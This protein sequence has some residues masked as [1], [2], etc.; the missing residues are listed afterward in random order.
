MS[1]TKAP[2]DMSIPEL[3]EWASSASEPD[4]ASALEAEVGGK[5]RAGAVALLSPKADTATQDDPADEEEASPYASS[6]PAP[7][8]AGVTASEVAAF[9]EGHTAPSDL[10][11]RFNNDDTRT[12]V[13]SFGPGERGVNLIL[14]GETV[15]AHHAAQVK[16]FRDAKAF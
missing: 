5:N 16:V 13:K 2:A 10:Y 14:A 1:D 8:A 9:R 11:V 4:K 12:L 15:A 3:T 7:E 6:A